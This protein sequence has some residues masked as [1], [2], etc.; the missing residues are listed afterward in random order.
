MGKMVN[1]TGVQ[2]KDGIATEPDQQYLYIA[3]VAE[4]ESVVKFD[5]ARHVF[6][7]ISLFIHLT[8]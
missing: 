4:S 6:E 8:T 5:L 7:K 2:K 3:G 1:Y